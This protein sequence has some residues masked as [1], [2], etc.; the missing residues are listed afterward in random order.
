MKIVG[1]LHIVP[2]FAVAQAG[3]EPCGNVVPTEN[4]S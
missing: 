3:N 1:L 4:L 2:P